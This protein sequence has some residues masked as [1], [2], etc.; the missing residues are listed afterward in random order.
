[1]TDGLCGLSD[2]QMLYKEFTKWFG[3]IVLSF[4]AF[5]IPMRGFIDDEEEQ[6]IKME[7]IFNRI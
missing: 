6:R 5:G 3:L 7:E 1:M 2:E 4:N